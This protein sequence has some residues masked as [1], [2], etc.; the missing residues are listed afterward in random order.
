MERSRSTVR[1]LAPGED[2]KVDVRMARRGDRKLRFRLL[3][4]RR[5]RIVARRR[6]PARVPQISRDL[7]CR[8]VMKP[9]LARVLH[10]VRCQCAGA[11]GTTPLPPGVVAAPPAG[12]A[13]TRLRSPSR[14][15]LIGLE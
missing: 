1:H 9:G 12:M 13:L 11:D 8:E 6:C 14:R 10:R 5:V 2:V 4:S 15:S 3:T 7:P